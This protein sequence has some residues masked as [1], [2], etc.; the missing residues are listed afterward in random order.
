MSLAG[1]VLLAWREHQ[2]QLQQLCTYGLLPSFI[3]LQAVSCQWWQHSRTAAAA[4]H[5]ACRA[6]GDHWLRLVLHKNDF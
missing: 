6:S 5:V 4:Y 1:A 2:L 3:F